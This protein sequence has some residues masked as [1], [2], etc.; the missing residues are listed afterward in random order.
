MDTAIEYYHVDNSVF[1]KGV[2]Y[3]VGAAGC[4][5]SAFLNYLMGK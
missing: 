4:G 1:K 2:V 3:M 5:Q